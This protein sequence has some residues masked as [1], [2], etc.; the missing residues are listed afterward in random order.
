MSYM[1][2]KRQSAWSGR[3]SFVTV[4]LFSNQ[5]EDFQAGFQPAASSLYAGRSLEEGIQSLCSQVLT[6]LMLG[7]AAHSF[8]VPYEQFGM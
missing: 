3:L 6:T 5:G 7:P 8:F 4:Q 1:S 2:K